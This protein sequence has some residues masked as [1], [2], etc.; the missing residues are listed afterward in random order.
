M[1][2][3]IV[4]IELV[5]RVKIET[6]KEFFEDVLTD[7][8]RDQV[9]KEYSVTLSAEDW[10]RDELDEDEDWSECILGMLHKRKEQYMVYHSENYLCH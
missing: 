1:T 6:F 4:D 5:N 10:M 8:E 2:I 9:L 3:I 7:E